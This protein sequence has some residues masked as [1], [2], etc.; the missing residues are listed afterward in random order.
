MVLQ[1]RTRLR[2]L[3]GIEVPIV[4]AGMASYTDARLVAAVSNAGGLGLLG[5]VG[6]T[7]DEIVAEIDRIR[8]LTDRAFGVNVVIA[9][10]LPEI[11]DAVVA[12]R[13]PVVSTSWGDPGPGIDRI[14]AAGSKALHQVTTVAGAREAA[15]AGVDAIIAQGTDGGGHVGQ[16]GTMAIVPQVVDAAAGVPVIAAGGIVDGRGLA[17]AL[18]LGAEGVF[19][20]TRFLATHEASIPE[21]WKAALLAAAAERAVATNIPDILWKVNPWPGATCRVLQNRLIDNW[22][23]RESLLAERA[24]EVAERVAVAREA[25]DFDDVPLYA[26]QGAGAITEMLPAAEVVRRMVEEAEQVIRRLRS[27]PD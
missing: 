13:P 23:S 3:L 10:A 26:G 6:R 2:E 4:L 5:S 27:A 11:W 24:E 18:A 20:G 19:V 14:R 17:A 8:G 1:L 16:V 12:A 15:A 22:L 25:G 7:P 9:D 21:P